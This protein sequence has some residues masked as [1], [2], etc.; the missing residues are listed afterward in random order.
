V[1]TSP[2]RA[3]AAPRARATAR[4]AERARTDVRAPVSSIPESGQRYSVTDVIAGLMAAGSILLSFIA[5]GFGIILT[6]EPR[7]ARLAPVAA[8]VAL[9]AGRMSVRYQRLALAAVFASMVAFVVG[10]SLA[11]ITKHP[12]I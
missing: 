9:V 11:V 12:I 7:P 1:A 3:K 5:T 4:T 8:I 10:M 2:P 6:I